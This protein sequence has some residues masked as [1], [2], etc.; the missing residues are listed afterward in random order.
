MDMTTEVAR[1]VAAGVVRVMQDKSISEV[2]LSEQTGI[3]RTTL[4]RRLSG[5]SAFNVAELAA[6][7]TVLGVD[8]ALLAAGRDAA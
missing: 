6:I 2:Q 3:P 1:Q 7:A 8:F 4:K 5:H